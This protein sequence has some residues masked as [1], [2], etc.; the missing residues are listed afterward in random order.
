MKTTIPK[1]IKSTLFAA[2]TTAL[3][4]FA[5]QDIGAQI[6]VNGGF[7]NPIVTLPPTYT[8]PYQSLPNDIL[9]G[10]TLGATYTGNEGAQTAV[11]LWNSTYPLDGIQPQSGNQYI[12]IEG[13][14]TLSQSV[15]ISAGTYTLS[16]GAQGRTGF[17]TP[18]LMFMLGTTSITFEA[19]TTLLPASGSWITY[20]SDTFVVETTGVYTFIISG[21]DPI[22]Q[23]SAVIDNVS[24]VPVPEP[25]AVVMTVLGGL[26]SL[27]ITRRR[28][29]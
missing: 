7:E 26:V 9:T 20:T 3:M 28:R 2:L 29:N 23:G 19:S 10:W 21:T 12:E 17:V 11:G 14:G 18:P 6:I 4:T 27:A 25:G 13:S 1:H 24:I 16:L 15:T 5:S 22:L 8:A